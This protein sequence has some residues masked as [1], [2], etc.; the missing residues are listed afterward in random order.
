MSYPLFTLDKS[1]LFTF[2]LANLL[3]PLRLFRYA[4]IHV[5]VSRVVHSAIRR[6]AKSF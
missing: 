1:A 3:G 5:H 2:Y 6:D 4:D